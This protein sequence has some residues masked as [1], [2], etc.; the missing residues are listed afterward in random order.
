MIKRLLRWLLRLVVSVLVVLAIIL[1]SDFV[2]HRYR[3]GTVLVLELN[4]PMPERG[5][6]SVS[7]GPRTSA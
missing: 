7:A 1:V 4:G 3:P 6:G 5:S 2:S